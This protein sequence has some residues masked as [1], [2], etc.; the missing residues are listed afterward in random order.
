M[1]DIG[2]KTE[3]VEAS[4]KESNNDVKKDEKFVHI[5][6][7]PSP[8]HAIRLLSE[9]GQSSAI[10]V[11]VSGAEMCDIY[12]AFYGRLNMSSWSLEDKQKR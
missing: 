6:T 9:K 10:R 12:R 3:M 8:L 11:K 7:S 4:A 5:L 1:S 2:L